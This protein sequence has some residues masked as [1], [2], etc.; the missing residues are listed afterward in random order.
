M[1][2]RYTCSYQAKWVGVAVENINSAIWNPLKQ[3]FSHVKAGRARANDSESEFFFVLNVILPLNHFLVLRV[4]VLGKNKGAT[5]SLLP[6][7]LGRVA[8]FSVFESFF[9]K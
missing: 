3:I 9:G 1:V 5:A 7:F 6:G 4:V 2:R 8:E